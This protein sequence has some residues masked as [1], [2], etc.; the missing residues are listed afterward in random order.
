MSSYYIAWR[1]D[2]TLPIIYIYQF[3][4]KYKGLLASQVSRSVCHY[5][6]VGTQAFSL[7]V[8]QEQ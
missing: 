3:K 6:L 5:M 8:V 1:H 7:L 4:E 2:Q